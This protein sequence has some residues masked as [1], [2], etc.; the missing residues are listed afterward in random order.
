MGAAG[1]S[2]AL[3]G[4]ALAVSLLSGGGVPPD[5][6]LRALRLSAPPSR[7]PGSAPGSA[8]GAP[9]RASV[10]PLAVARVLAS[11]RGVWAGGALLSDVRVPFVGEDAVS[12]ERAE[13]HSE[14]LVRALARARRGTDAV[15]QAQATLGD[16]LVLDAE[17]RALDL[18]VAAGSARE[19]AARRGELPRPVRLALRDPDAADSLMALSLDLAP[20]P[21]S[22]TSVLRAQWSEQRVTCSLSVEGEVRHLP[23]ISRAQ[24][25]E[26]LERA[27]AAALGR[28]DWTLDVRR[29]SL[30]AGAQAPLRELAALARLAL[31]YSAEGVARRGAL[32]LT[33]SFTL[34]S[35]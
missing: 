35:R 33:L 2:L 10:A 21:P 1:L 9:L 6:A 14:A 23:P 15:A 27:L 19:A 3:I 17:L 4:G 16:L 24:G 30:E 8:S 11:P 13:L 32:P 28:V 12:N 5:E 34:T 20:T 29:L 25:P 18:W 7:D 22:A 31:V 26:A